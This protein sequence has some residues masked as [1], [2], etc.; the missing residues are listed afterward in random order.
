MWSVVNDGEAGNYESRRRSV[1]QRTADA[2]DPDFEEE[3]CQSTWAV[4]AI[5]ACSKYVSHY[6]FIIIG[7]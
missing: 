6:H 4:L 7:L 2:E 5:T 3:V 1:S